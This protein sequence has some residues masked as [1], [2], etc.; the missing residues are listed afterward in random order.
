[1]GRIPP[2]TARSPAPTCLGK[3]SYI[4]NWQR[5]IRRPFV[6]KNNYLQGATTECV[7]SDS[8]WKPTQKV[9]PFLLIKYPRY[10]QTAERR[11]T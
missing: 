1:M 4:K 11:L 2:S 9:L 6:A 3:I 7:E 5:P 10:W 8:A